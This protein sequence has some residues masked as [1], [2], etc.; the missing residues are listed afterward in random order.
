MELP[1]GLD[2]Y[3]IISAALAN[4]EY[5]DK[6]LFIVGTIWGAGFITGVLVCAIFVHPDSELSRKKGKGK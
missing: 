4:P 2:V 1:N 3:A 6:I 5:R